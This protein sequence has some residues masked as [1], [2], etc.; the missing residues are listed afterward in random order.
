M[1]LQHKRFDRSLSAVALVYRLYCCGF[2]ASGSRSSATTVNVLIL[3][4]VQRGALKSW[5]FV[6][7]MLCR[8]RQA[9][10]HHR[11]VPQL[12]LCVSG[13]SRHPK[14]MFDRK[15]IAQTAS[16]VVGGLVLRVRLVSNSNSCDEWVRPAPATCKCES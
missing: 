2:W 1:C 14:I 10:G 16:F 7:R 4:T 11:P 13:L 5:E 12:G 3:L 8:E 9:T 6:S 15:K